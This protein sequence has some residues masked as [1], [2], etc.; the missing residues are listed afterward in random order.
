MGELFNSAKAIRLPGKAA[1]DVVL[2]PDGAHELKVRLSRDSW[3]DT[4]EQ[5]VQVLVELSFDDGKSWQ[6]WIGFGAHG[7]DIRK[8]DGLASSESTVYSM[9]PEGI[10][11]LARVTADYK[12][13]LMTGVTVEAA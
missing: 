1:G 10:S 6:P 5:V 2:I 7:G 11:R 4:G 9:L 13:G 12:T 3:P 8:A